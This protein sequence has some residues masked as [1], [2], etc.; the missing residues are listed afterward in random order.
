M[1]EASNPGPA[2]FLRRLRRG[3][4]TISE[5]ASTVPASAQDV[6]AAL[7]EVGGSPTVVDMSADDSDRGG[8]VHMSGN[9]FAVLGEDVELDRLDPVARPRRRLVLVSQNPDFVGSNHEWDPDTES[10]G[11]A[12]EVDGEEVPEQSLFETPIAVEPRVHA[13]GRAFASL[14]SVNLLDTINDRPRLMQ[15]VPWVLR[16]AFRSAIQDALQEIVTGSAANDEL[17]ATRCW[18]LLLLLPRMILF[19]PSRGGAVP[20]RKLEARITAFQ[21]GAWLELLAE[22]ACCA[23]KALTQS[24]RRRRRQQSDDDGKRAARALSLVYMGELSAARQALESAPVAPGTMATLRAL[25]DPEKRPPVPRDDLSGVVAELQPAAKFEL[26]SVEFLVCLRRARRG[27]AAGPSGMTSDHLFPVLESEVASELLSQVASL[28]SVGQVPHT[29]LEAIRLGRLTA[30]QK[31]DGGVRGIVVG[32]IIRRLVARTIAKQISEKVEA[33]TAPFQYA[34]K[35]KAGCECVAHVLQTL[36]DLDPE[37]TIMSIDGVGA[38]DLISRNAMLEGLL[39]LE[40][41]DQILPFVRMFYGSP[42]TYLWEDEMGVTQSIPQGEGGEQGDPLMPMLFALGQHGALEATQAR[43]GAGEYVFAYLD[44]IYTATGPARV[45]GAHVAVE[46]E[47]WSHARIHL[48]HGK[49]Q[50]WNRGGTEPSG[51]EVLTQAARAVKPGAVVWHGDPLL[52][53][54]QQGLKVLGVPIGRGAFVEHFLEYKSTEQQVLFQR[55]PL[56]E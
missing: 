48:H 29:I 49:T 19:R 5:V 37:A 50:V 46:E 25:T 39:R 3:A 42:S 7:R 1:G 53:P 36:T 20:R 23:E 16:G 21:Q 9:R 24:V 10:I 4:S 47:L 28:L 12:S 27:A 55:I 51:M 2:K 26:D 11:G 30:L 17:K 34:L 18:K 22:G 15:T 35:T 31:P 40:G 45:D 13:H 43:L 38:H 44:D 32:D 14:D 33:A 52:P 54:V 6:Q 8:Q 41:G 56:G